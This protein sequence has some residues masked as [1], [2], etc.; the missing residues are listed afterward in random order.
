MLDAERLEHGRDVL[1]LDVL[2]VVRVAIDHLAAAKREDLDDAAV[3]LERHSEDVD[4][5]DGAA[6]RRL[7][8][9]E[10]LDGEEPVAVARRVLEALLVGS[11]AHLPL[12]LAL[13]RLGVAARGTAR[14]RR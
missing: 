2:D 7:P 6:V 13:D 10:V 1:L 5:A 9:R 4:V 3:A 12:E 14:R 8:L 11:L